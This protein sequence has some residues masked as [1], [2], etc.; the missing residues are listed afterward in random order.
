[1]AHQKALC[2]SLDVAHSF[3]FRKCLFLNVPRFFILVY[4]TLPIEYVG[5]GDATY[6]MF[7]LIPSP[8]ADTNCFCDLKEY[9]GH[10]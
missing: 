8:K 9:E 5:M 10:L 2:S 1:M 4:I 3:S 6:F 7:N